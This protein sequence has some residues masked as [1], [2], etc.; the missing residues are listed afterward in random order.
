MNRQI[1]LAN[2]G[3][4]R[5]KGDALLLR[6]ADVVLYPHLF[7]EDESNQLLDELQW[8]IAWKSETISLY[9]K[10]MQQPRLTAWYG[11]P[12]CSYTYSHLTL[13]PHPWIP[14]LGQ[15]K[16]KV[17]ALCD[18][19]FNSVLLNLYR[20]G[21][22]SMG[23]HSDDESELGGNPV[24][25]SVSFG[26]TRRFRL[27]H[28]Y[29]TNL[30]FEIQLTHGIFLLMQGTTQHFWHH[31]IPKTQRLIKPRINLTFRRILRD[32]D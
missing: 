16:S 1:D 10:R 6:D 25:G 27:R 29:Q 15:I 7:G 30:K 3:S 14:V 12:G 19:P 4:D 28:R 24:I 17:E 18:R 26:E 20:D 8:A 23:W 11:D 31:Q 32:S 9:G 22:D 2:N 21:Q 13:T 5:A